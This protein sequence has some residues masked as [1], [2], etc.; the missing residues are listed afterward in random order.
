[1]PR[2][3]YCSLIVADPKLREVPSEDLLG[4]CTLLQA[5]R[6][7]LSRLESQLKVKLPCN[8]SVFV[9]TCS[10]LKIFVVLFRYSETVQFPELVSIF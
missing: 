10:K 4:N 6:N 2:K 5:V 1:M 3:K 8:E 7:S 9:F